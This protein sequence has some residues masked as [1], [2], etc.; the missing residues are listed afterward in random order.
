MV[1]SYAIIG[2]KMSPVDA[3]GKKNKNWGWLGVVR[4]LG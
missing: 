2:S 3:T 4:S 1:T